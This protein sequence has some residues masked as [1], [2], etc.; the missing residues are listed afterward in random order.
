[1][2]VSSQM[3]LSFPF[4]LF[5]VSH[6]L[7]KKASGV[8]LCT[9]ITNS[10]EKAM[11]G[12]RIAGETVESFAEIVEGIDRTSLTFSEIAKSISEQTNEITAINTNIDEVSKI[13][14]ENSAASEQNAAVSEELNSQSEVLAKAVSRF[15]ISN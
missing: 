4:N 1:M 2:A 11:L 15:K 3:N 6:A 10:S 9:L 7:I 5:A 8:A 12:A 13:V 14:Q